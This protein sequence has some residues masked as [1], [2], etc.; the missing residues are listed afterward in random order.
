MGVEGGSR[1]GTDMNLT[2]V[3]LILSLMQD[4]N[5]G[6]RHNSPELMISSLEMVLSYGYS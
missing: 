4:R 6:H 2:R 5:I 1:M 3:Q